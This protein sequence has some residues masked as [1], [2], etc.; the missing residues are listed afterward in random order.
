ME[1]V[2]NGFIYMS[3]QIT[4]YTLSI[5]FHMGDQGDMAWWLYR[6]H[7]QKSNRASKDFLCGIDSFKHAALVMDFYVKALL[8]IFK[9]DMYQTGVDSHVCVYM[10]KADDERGG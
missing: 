9:N 3:V 8:V 5:G 7:H 10:Y 4:S 1:N 2:N 6:N